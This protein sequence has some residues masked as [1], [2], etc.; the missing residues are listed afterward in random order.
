MEGHLPPPPRSI[1]DLKP[2][3]IGSLI[4]GLIRIIGGLTRVRFHDRAGFSTGSHPGQY[5]IA[6]WHNRMVVMPLI[7]SR[8]H[9]RKGAT[10]LTSTSREG[11]M[12]ARVVRSFG[13]DVVRGSSSRRGAAAALALRE[14]MG[15]GYDVIVTP[16]GPRGPRYRLGAGIV[17]LSQHSGQP[18][19]PIRV[20]YSRYIELKSWDRLRI[21]LPFSRIDV[22]LEPLLFAQPTNSDESFESERLRLEQA[23]QINV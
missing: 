18:V 10:V 20:D 17:F 16:D 11:A 14:R 4:A 12:V 22:T 7:F 15:K 19:L 3:L 21:P 9:R 6:F 1:R 8:Y 23:M 2:L 5:I 13:M